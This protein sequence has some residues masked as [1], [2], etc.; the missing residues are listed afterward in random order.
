MSFISDAVRMRGSFLRG[1]GR[2]CDGI[3]GLGGCDFGLVGVAE[4]GEER[5]FFCC[6]GGFGGSGGAGDGH[7]GGGG[8]L[9]LFLFLEEVVFC[10]ILLGEGACI[11]LLL[12]VF[13]W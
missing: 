3:G 12:V 8:F 4:A 11:M 10:E 2:S 7:G 9:V 13:L 5:G 6:G 1:G